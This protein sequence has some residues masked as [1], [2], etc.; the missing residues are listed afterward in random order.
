MYFTMGNVQVRLFVFSSCTTEAAVSAEQSEEPGENYR[1]NVSYKITRSECNLADGVIFTGN[2][3][4]TLFFKR[5]LVENCLCILLW[6]ISRLFVTNCLFFNL[7]GT[8]E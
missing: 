3:I 6:K 4:H 2:F 7:N 5:S 8:S 1:N